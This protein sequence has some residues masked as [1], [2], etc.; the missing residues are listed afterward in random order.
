MLRTMYKSK[1]HGAKVTDAR[2]DY[3]GSIT[4]DQELMEA[5]D[6]YP[7]ERVQVLNS[8]NGS[9]LETY[10]IEGK[11]GTG[12]MCMNGPAA[13]WAQVGDT[14]MVVSYCILSDEEARRYIPRI[15]FVDKKN[16]IEKLIR[17]KTKKTKR[18]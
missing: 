12:V 11:A 8:S 6:I 18:R 10:V 9:R 13:R 14:V 1:I 4:I 16:K 17:G 2:L 3:M 15:I 7:H 5:A